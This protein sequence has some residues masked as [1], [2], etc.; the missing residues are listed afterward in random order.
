MDG[1]MTE[2]MFDFPHDD[3]TSSRPGTWCRVWTLDNDQTAQV[4]CPDCGTVGVLDLRDFTIDENGVVR[5]DVGC[6]CGYSNAIR[7]VPWRRQ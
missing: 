2:R 7:L 5:P 6:V 1:R 4:A 3:R